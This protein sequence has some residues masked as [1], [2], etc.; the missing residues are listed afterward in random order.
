MR[1]IAY[2]PPHLE[3]PL[4]LTIIN[5]GTVSG[6]AEMYDAVSDAF[7][8]SLYMRGRGTHQC[9][10][11]RALPYAPGT[12]AVSLPGKRYVR[13]PHHGETIEA[14]WVNFTGP[15]AHELFKRY[16]QPGPH[17]LDASGDPDSRRNLTIILRALKRGMPEDLVFAHSVLITLIVETLRKKKAASQTKVRDEVRDFIQ[18]CRDHLSESELPLSDFKG[19]NRAH[20]ETFRKKFRKATGLAPREYWLIAKLAEAKRLLAG[21]MQVEEIAA[22]TGFE[23][24]AYFSRIFK[25]KEG[26]TP[27]EFRR[28]EI[29]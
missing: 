7:N 9:E 22:R 10:G 20:Y 23:T 29:F 15:M 14:C 17:L 26:I 16:D 12:I 21:T 27:T 4:G 2:A 18:F 6:Q 11:A 5:A 25:K 28:R 8:I 13:R 3:S 24:P 1:R 19:I